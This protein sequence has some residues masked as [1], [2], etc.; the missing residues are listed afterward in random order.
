LNQ[1][2]VRKKSLNILVK[3]WKFEF[4][5]NNREIATGCYSIM[6]FD[7]DLMVKT[8]EISNDLK[9]FYSLCFINTDIFAVGNA[10]GSIHIYSKEEKKKKHKMED[11]SLA[12]RAMAYDNVNKRLLAASDDLHINIID[13]ERFN[14]I[15]PMV[16]HKE[17][18][19][20]LAVNSELGIYASASND[21]C[22]K[23]WDTKQAKC[24]QTINLN[25]SFSTESLNDGNFL[26]DIAFSSSGKELICGSD[27]GCHFL[28]LA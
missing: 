23:L 16:G 4:D 10:N 6:F 25:S 27:S 8:L 11:N 17:N 28:T 2:Y 13:A 21:G 14:V 22:I 9:Y 24:I 15:I 20:A 1:E 26:W 7:L 3:T 19:T 18:I 12:I 5:P